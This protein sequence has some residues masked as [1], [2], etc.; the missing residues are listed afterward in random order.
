VPR[1]VGANLE[2]V[3]TLA[4]G[5]RSDVA[6]G[7]SAGG[8]ASISY[9][10]PSVEMIDPTYSLSGNI[11]ADFVVTGEHFGNSQRDL[12]G[13]TVG[14]S[15][16]ASSEWVSHTEVRCIGASGQEW[17][18]RGVV[19]QVAG[20]S[21][22]ANALFEPMGAPEVQ[23]VSPSESIAG[24]SILVLGSNFGDKAED[25]VEVTIGGVPCDSI[26]HRGRTAVTCIVPV[27][28]VAMGGSISDASYW[29]QFRNLSVVVQTAGGLM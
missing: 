28:N 27:A 3:V 9:D 23:T 8:R 26:S 22:L 12:D 13:I 2:V 18:S 15:T 29:A 17:D 6:E 1:G 11:S 16:C 4:G 24:A 10:L 20:Q 7:V 14:G 19:V 25:V 5:I 21:S